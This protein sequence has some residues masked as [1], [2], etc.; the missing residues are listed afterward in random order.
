MASAS[1]TAWTVIATL[2]TRRIDTPLWTQSAEIAA[3]ATSLASIINLILLLRGL[4]KLLGPFDWKKNG[5]SICKSIFSSIIMGISVLIFSKFVI[6]STGQ[7][8]VYFLSGVLGAV[9]TGIIIYIA[10]SFL[11]KS[12]ELKNIMTIAEKRTD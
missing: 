6:T 10:I 9:V 8:K 2:W 5:L 12:E 3:L 4:K 7:S 11:F 1:F